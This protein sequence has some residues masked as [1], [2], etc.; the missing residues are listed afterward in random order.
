[1]NTKIRLSAL[2]LPIVLLLVTA[3]SACSGVLTSEQPA[4]QYYTLMPLKNNGSAVK[5]DTLPALTIS[6]TAVPGL[7]TDRILALG[8]DARLHRY[9]NARWPD[10]LP[11]VLTSVL[12][13]SLLASGNFSAVHSGTSTGDV[14]GLEL[15]VQQFYG[16]R[17]GSGTTSSVLVEMAGELKC[18]GDHH[19]IGLSD[20]SRVAVERRSVI[21]AALQ[22]RLYAV[23]WLLL[24]SFYEICSSA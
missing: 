14:W 22:A 18:S 20:S 1:M 24:A 15:E 11:E 13:R 5:V 6:V 3:L 16:T 4:K 9:A 21:V 19:Q 23:S 2:T 17:D 10:H 12:K 8:A 7:D